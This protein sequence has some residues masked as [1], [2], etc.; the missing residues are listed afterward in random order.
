MEDRSHQVFIKVTIVVIV[1]F[2]VS[3]YLLLTA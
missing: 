1:I 3:V 2:W